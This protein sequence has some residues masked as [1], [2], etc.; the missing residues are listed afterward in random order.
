MVVPQPIDHDSRREG[1]ERIGDPARERR[2]PGR[3]RRFLV[4]QERGPEHGEPR[5]L[6]FRPFSRG[7]TANQQIAFAGLAE[8][9]RVDLRR[10][11]QVGE[12]RAHLGLAPHQAGALELIGR[13]QPARA[14]RARASL[15]DRTGT[16][17]IEEATTVQ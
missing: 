7:I 1:I 13:L 15:W 3:L 17:S 11:A 5:R 9:S 12:Q 8:R 4:E 6:H 10:R 14:R 16:R 2:S